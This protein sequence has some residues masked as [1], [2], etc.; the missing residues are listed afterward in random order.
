VTHT[1][2]RKKLRTGDTTASASKQTRGIPPLRVAVQ[3]VPKIRPAPLEPSAEPGYLDPDFDANVND[4][5]PPVGEDFELRPGANDAGPI[6]PLH[7]DEPDLFAFDAVPQDQ[8]KRRSLPPSSRPPSSELD[9]E[10]PKAQS[11]REPKPRPSQRK[12]SEPGPSQRGPSQHASEPDPSIQPQRQPVEYEY[13]DMDVDMDMNLDDDFPFPVYYQQP[14]PQPQPQQSQQSQHSHS[15]PHLHHQSSRHP[16]PLQQPIYSPHSQSYLEHGYERGPHQQPNTSNDLELPEGVTVFVPDT[17]PGAAR[18]AVYRLPQNLKEDGIFVPPTLDGA[19][20]SSQ[21]LPTPSPPTPRQLPYAEPNVHIHLDDAPRRHHDLELASDPPQPQPHTL[22]LAS[23]DTE[24]EVLVPGTSEYDVPA[25]YVY[26]SAMERTGYEFGSSMWTP[27]PSGVEVL[28]PG[29]EKVLAMDTPLKRT[30][31]MGRPKGWVEKAREESREQ[32]SPA[33][34]KVAQLAGKDMR[35]QP[36]PVLPPPPPTK[37]R[38][39]PPVVLRAAPPV[40]GPSRQQPLPLNAVRTPPSPATFFDKP[41]SPVSFFAGPPSPVSFFDNKPPSPVSFF[42]PAAVS[43]V[44][45]MKAKTKPRTSGPAFFI[46]PDLVRAVERDNANAKG[47]DKGKG[48]ARAIAA[49]LLPSIQPVQTKGSNPTSKSD[50]EP[51][52]MLTL[53]EMSEAYLEHASVNAP[54]VKQAERAERREEKRMAKRK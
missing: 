23:S 35:V 7:Q 36:P 6:S 13:M 32:G 42:D 15:G 22:D 19:P 30:R 50:S 14:Q 53:L 54:L 24:G 10:S 47:K 4:W 18:R 16:Q 8:S 1:R 12:A 51:R 48:K 20:S 52:R 26:D 43:P 5:G 33:P 41:P 25:S 31:G 39:A 27:L 37:A 34:A 49:P 9:S 46:D 29:T 2:H 17:P 45:A 40:P 11:Q 21:N 28:V 38:L 44:T 3:A